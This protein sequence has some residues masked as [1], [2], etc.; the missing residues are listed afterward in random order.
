MNKL[1]LIVF[2]LFPFFPSFPQYI[3]SPE[4]K[5][6]CPDNLKFAFVDNEIGNALRKLYPNAEYVTIDGV[7]LDTA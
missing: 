4:I 6:G 1:T 5:V 7:R 2:S 3:S